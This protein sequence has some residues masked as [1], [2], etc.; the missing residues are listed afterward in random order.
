MPTSAL[1]STYAMSSKRLCPAQAHHAAAGWASDES[2]CG[3]KQASSVTPTQEK[4]APENQ[5]RSNTT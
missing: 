1:T 5:E 4:S 2:G 3:I